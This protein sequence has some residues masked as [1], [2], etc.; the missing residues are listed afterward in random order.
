MGRIDKVFENDIESE[1]ADQREV[2]GRDQMKVVLLGAC[3]SSGYECGL[4]GFRV[5]M[6]PL[7]PEW[8]PAWC[9]VCDLSA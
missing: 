3:V 9:C 8:G 4:W 1:M 6:A 7:R 2:V 5:P